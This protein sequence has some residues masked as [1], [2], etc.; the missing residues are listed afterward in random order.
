MEISFNSI[1]ENYNKKNDFLTKIWV[2]VALISI[3]GLIIIAKYDSL[4]A[5]IDIPVIC[6]K[7]PVKYFFAIYLVILNGLTIRWIEAFHR[8]ILLRQNVIEKILEKNDAIT[9]QKKQIN[10]RNFIDGIVNSSTTSI[11]GIVP[12][13]GKR[14]SKV[15]IAC[16][17]LLAYFILKVVVFIAHFVLP[18]LTIVIATIK[19]EDSST[20]TPI[21]IKIIVYFISVVGLLTILRAVVS[22][23]KYGKTAYRKQINRNPKQ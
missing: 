20:S 17:R 22:E 10:S 9:I 7:V 16:F 1:I 15:P 2:W 12:D 11:W 14:N 6:L 5:E 4:S 23:F 3:F 13:W 8:S 19:L 18:F 21:S